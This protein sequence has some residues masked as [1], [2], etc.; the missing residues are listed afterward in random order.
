MQVRV[1]DWKET[2]HQK[3]VSGLNIGSEWTHSTWGFVVTII[4]IDNGI[5][6]SFNEDPKMVVHVSDIND[7][8]TKF[9]RV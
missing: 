2:L 8:V 9:S 5:D 6:F 1:D 4:G 7:F 3:P